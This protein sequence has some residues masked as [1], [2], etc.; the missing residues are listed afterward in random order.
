M[1]LRTVCDH[2]YT[3]PLSDNH[4]PLLCGSQKY[5]SHRNRLSFSPPICAKSIWCTIVK[6]R[7]STSSYYTGVVRGVGGQRP[8]LGIGRSKETLASAYVLRPLKTSVI[9]IYKRSEE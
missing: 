7:I 8:G 4:S 1:I 2:L 9:S 6:N 3:T 5:M